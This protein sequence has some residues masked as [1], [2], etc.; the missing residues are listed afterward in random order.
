MA[1]LNSE[2][3]AMLTTFAS[4]GGNPSAPTSQRIRS[5][6]PASETAPLPA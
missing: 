1:K 5:T 3:A 6:L 4:S 2:Q